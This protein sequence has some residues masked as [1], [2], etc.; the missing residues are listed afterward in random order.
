MH[1]IGP[2]RVDNRR[3]GGALR[4]AILALRLAWKIL[5]G[6]GIARLGHGFDTRQKHKA[7]DTRPPGGLDQ[8]ARSFKVD[9]PV[10]TRLIAGTGRKRMGITGAVNHAVNTGTGRLQGR[11]I[12]Q[13]C[14]RSARTASVATH[15]RTTLITATSKR[16]NYLATD[17]TS[18]ASNQIVIGCAYLARC[19]HRV[20]HH[21]RIRICARRSG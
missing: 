21:L 20:F 7:A 8:V 12:G 13:I 2:G 1:P 6:T 18:A 5:I 10:L 11:H 4:Q 17:E 14:P 15:E 3:F 9:L 19:R 16:G